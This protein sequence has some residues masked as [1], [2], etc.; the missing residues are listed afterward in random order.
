MRG[1]SI[2]LATDAFLGQESYQALVIFLHMNGFNLWALL[3]VQNISKVQTVRFSE[4][5]DLQWLQS[6]SYALIGLQQRR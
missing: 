6:L 2:G 5:D 3:L 4:Q 1:S